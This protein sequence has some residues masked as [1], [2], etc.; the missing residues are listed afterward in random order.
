MSVLAAPDMTPQLQWG[1]LTYPQ[2]SMS[3]SLSSW[4]LL[5]IPVHP[6]FSLAEVL[7]NKIN[8]ICICTYICITSCNL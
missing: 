6:L 3:Q 8:L 7:L 1:D 5:L 4:R 2:A